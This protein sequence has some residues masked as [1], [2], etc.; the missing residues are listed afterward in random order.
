MKKYLLFCVTFLF[1]IFIFLNRVDAY[2]SNWDNDFGNNGYIITDVLQPVE[3]GYDIVNDV[4]VQNDGKYIQVGYTENQD[5][6]WILFVVRYNLDGTIDTS[7]A[8]NGKF[9]F[10][11]EYYSEFAETVLVLEDGRILVGGG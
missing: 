6:N 11:T 7:F 5:Y 4:V 10:Y 3:N 9:L 1:S 2:V 8:N